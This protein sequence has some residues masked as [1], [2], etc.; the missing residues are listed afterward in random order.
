[1]LI[2]LVEITLPAASV[3]DASVAF[4]NPFHAIVFVWNTQVFLSPEGLVALL[5]IPSVKLNTGI[6]T[7]ASLKTA[8]KITTSPILA[9]SLF[10]VITAVGA[11]LSKR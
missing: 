8:V 3:A 7:N 5:A 4:T 11:T 6:P 1:M 2:P 9:T 10:D